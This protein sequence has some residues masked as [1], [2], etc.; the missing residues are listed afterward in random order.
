VNVEQL[1]VEGAPEAEDALIPGTTE[2]P[3]EEKDKYY[4]D[5]LDAG[6]QEPAILV[7]D[8]PI[9]NRLQWLVA[10]FILT[11]YALS[12]LLTFSLV[13][14]HSAGILTIPDVLLSWLGPAILGEIAS[15]TWMIVRYLFGTTDSRSEQQSVVRPSSTT[16][17]H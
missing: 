13:A 17:Q 11:I 12:V 2:L 1:P 4:L 5:P 6:V 7:S 15:T 10:W 16:R 9:R 3:I 8:T 14:L